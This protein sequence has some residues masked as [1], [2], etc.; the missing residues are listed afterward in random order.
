MNDHAYSE[1]EKAAIYRVIRERR[2]MRHFLPDSVDPDV[3]R[4]M[5][6]AAHDAPSV[7][8]MQP[9]RFVCIRDPSLREAMA[10]LVDDE[11]QATAQA[12]DERGQAFLELKVEGIR[13]CPELWVVAL[14]EAREQ[15]VFGRR[16][17]N[18]M[19][20]ASASCAIQNLWLAGRAEGI[21]VGWVSLFDPEALKSLINAPEG[22]W[23]IAILCMGHVEAFYSAPMLEEKGW[24]QRRSLAA[25]M[26]IDGWPE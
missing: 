16:T 22:A 1:A 10:R 17:L 15:Y 24:D 8:Y 11:R 7:G 13:E 14:C 9:W 20:L 18:E 26:G 12:L 6:E 4:R 5:L 2:D 19:D 3:I 23:P 25:L 21:G